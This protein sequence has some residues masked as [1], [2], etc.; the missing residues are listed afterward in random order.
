MHITECDTCGDLLTCSCV[1]G[2]R[3]PH[4]CL[5][6]HANQEEA[7]ERAQEAQGTLDF[8]AKC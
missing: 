2:P 5:E 7:T 3:A 4:L 1:S 6:C 8:E